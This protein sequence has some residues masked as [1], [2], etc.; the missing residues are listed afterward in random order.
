MDSMRLRASGSLEVQP[1][2]AG[3]SGGGAEVPELVRQ[4]REPAGRGP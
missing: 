4:H 3:V 2:L 1:L